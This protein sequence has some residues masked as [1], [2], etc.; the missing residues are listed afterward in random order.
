R[1]SPDLT[2]LPMVRNSRVRGFSFVRRS[3]PACAELTRWFGPILANARLLF[4]EIE[5][6]KLESQLR[7]N[8]RRRA[9]PCTEKSPG[10][11]PRQVEGEAE[12]R[13]AVEAKKCHGSQS[14]KALTGL[15]NRAGSW[16]K[17]VS[18]DTVCRA[19]DQLYDRT[20]DRRYERRRRTRSMSKKCQA[21][22]QEVL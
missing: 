17:P 19:L 4:K 13:K 7:R 2:Q 1:L 18:E 10:R 6:R 20:K 15:V 8:R 21:P 5:V 3:N 16:P 22:S 11:P 9:A 14:R 12:V